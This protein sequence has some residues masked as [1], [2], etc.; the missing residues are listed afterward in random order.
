VKKCSL[1]IV[2]LGRLEAAA[3]RLTGRKLSR[4]GTAG[5]A[6]VMALAW[7]K[8]AALIGA[9]FRGVRPWTKSFP[10]TVVMPR[11]TRALL[12]ACWTFEMAFELVG[13]LSGGI[14]F[15]P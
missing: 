10:E 8:L 2:R 12:I 7:R 13:F 11:R 3:G 14:A 4:V 1:F 9:E 5:T 6:P 15:A